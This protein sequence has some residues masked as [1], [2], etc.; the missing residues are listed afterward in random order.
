MDAKPAFSNTP[1]H[2]VNIGT[3]SCYLPEYSTPLEKKFYFLYSVSIH[4]QRANPITLI[5]RNWII[6]DGDGNQKKFKG[7]GVVGQT[8]IISSQSSFQYSSFCSLKTEWGSMEG[9]FT[10]QE[11]EHSFQVEIARFFLSNKVTTTP[12]PS[13]G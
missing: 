10:F 12:Y 6:I 3:K 2:Q 7:S 4:N 9:C 1:N 13:E 8:P 11:Q 5:G